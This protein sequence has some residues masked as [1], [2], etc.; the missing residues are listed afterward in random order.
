MMT[1]IFVGLKSVNVKEF[2]LVYQIPLHG[3]KISKKGSNNGNIL[4]LKVECDIE[5]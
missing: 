5:N 3:P 1:K 4:I 2:K